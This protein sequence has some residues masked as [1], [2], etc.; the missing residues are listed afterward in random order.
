MAY[1]VMRFPLWRLL[2]TGF[3]FLVSFRLAA[4]EGV[5]A[6]EYQ[7]WLDADYKINRSGS[8]GDALTWVIVQ[9]GEIVLG[10]NAANELAYTYFNNQTGHEYFAYLQKWGGSYYVRASNIVGYRFGL[11]SDAPIVTSARAAVALLNVP[12]RYV[13][14]ATG[15]A[16]KFTAANL[17]PGLA[18]DEQGVISG[19]PTQ[20]GHRVVALTAASG[21][22]VGTAGL[23]LSVVSGVNDGGQTNRYTLVLDSSYKVTWNPNPAET[24]LTMVVKRDGAVVLGRN[25]LGETHDGYFD[26]RTGSVYSIHFE[27]VVGAAYQRVSNIVYYQPGVAANFPLITS[28]LSAAGTLGVPFPGYQIVAQNSPTAF[29]A[30]GLPAGLAISSGGLISGT[31]GESGTFPVML[32][33]SNAT[34]TATKALTLTINASSSVGSLFTLT[35]DAQRVVRRSAGTLPGLCWVVREGGMEVLRRDASNED[36]FLYFRSGVS[37]SYTVHLE[38]WLNGAYRQVSNTTGSTLAPLAFLGESRL[39]VRAGQAIAPYSITLNGAYQTLAVGALPSGL[40]RNGTLITGTPSTPGV[41]PITMSATS[42]TVTA[43]RV[44]TIEVVTAANAGQPQETFSLRIDGNRTVTRNAGELDGLAWVVTKDGEIVLKRNAK[45]ELAY[46]YHRNFIAGA[47]TVYLEAFVQGRVSRVSNIVGYVTPT[48]DGAPVFVS[49]RRILLLAGR[50]ANL[51]LLASDAPSSYQAIGLPPGLLLSSAGIL[52]GTP[53]AAGIHPVTF[54]ATK[55]GLTGS[56]SFTLEIGVAA[57]SSTYADRH[58]LSIDG[59][60]TVARTPGDD[61]NLTWVIRRDGVEQLSRLA[62]DE[63][64]YCYYRNFEAGAYTVHLEAFLAGAYRVV[65]NT[66]NYTVAAGPGRALLAHALGAV[67]G[68]TTFL[69]PKLAVTTTASGAP[70]LGLTY[71]VN[72]TDG[73]VTVTLE[74]STNLRDWTTI[75]PERRI[76]GGDETFELREDV[77]PITG[78]GPRFHRVKIERAA[79]GN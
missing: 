47:F 71:T 41:Y 39:L 61:P 28:P 30:T 17:P 31:P 75:T 27:S 1:P 56:A 53:S 6:D 22:N 5:R 66:V 79:S 46:T 67:N 35:V 13:I 45:G 74:Q 52:S 65:S 37:S 50:P 68:T 23:A 38:A 12:F 19:T 51:Q 77:V 70:A 10:R 29:A 36:A 32:S 18:L 60:N 8:L 57:G 7:V 78:N 24:N 54:S 43:S 59:N 25:V 16:S 20:A 33:V 9:D 26:N 4:A 34:G 72:L 42:G 14:E 69:E 21:Q 11:V 15:N 49:P 58:R 44:L 2:V 62:R 55:A 63:L 76:L 48:H 64:S 40:V 73:A 3:L